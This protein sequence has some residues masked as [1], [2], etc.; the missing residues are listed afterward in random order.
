MQTQLC[1]IGLHVR[2]GL[3]LYLSIYHVIGRIRRLA[4]IREYE[5]TFAEYDEN[6]MGF[7]TDQGISKGSQC[8]HRIGQS[9]CGSR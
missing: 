2:H 8:G 1:H 6:I 5:N 4:R 3:N 9:E 7:E